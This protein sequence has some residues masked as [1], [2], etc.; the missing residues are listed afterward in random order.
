[1]SN[2]KAHNVIARYG[3]W[4][5]GDDDL[6]THCLILDNGECWL[7]GQGLRAAS[8]RVFKA[9]EEKF[10]QLTAAIAATIPAAWADA[11]YTG[12]N[13]ITDPE[14]PAATQIAVF[15]RQVSDP[16]ALGR[17]FVP[18]AGSEVETLVKEIAKIDP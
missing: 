11:G 8:L 2:S 3:N 1:M 4:Y 15:G 12:Y 16:P 13:F 5:R 9:P 17:Y 10:E 14:S 7:L 18:P 6:F